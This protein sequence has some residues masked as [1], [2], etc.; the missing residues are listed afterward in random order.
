M[1]DI[2]GVYNK[3]K[4]L[5]KWAFRSGE[6]DSGYVGEALY[7]LWQVVKQIV[8]SGTLTEPSK[9]E[10]FYKWLWEV[11]GITT[12]C[13]QCSGTGVRAYANT[14]TWIGGIGGQMVTKGVCD[15]CWGTGDENE[16]GV[17]QRQLCNQIQD[18]KRKVNNGKKH[19]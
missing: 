10:D 17:D 5:E 14:T 9:L 13:K 8:E 2:Q 12:P 6:L 4:G 19:R 15:V 3:H 11:R 7:E 16:K 1:I 18:L